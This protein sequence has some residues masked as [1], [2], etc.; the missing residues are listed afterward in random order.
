VFAGY[1]FDAV[2][3]KM[4]H[5]TLDYCLWE[6]AAYAL[7]QAAQPVYADKTQLLYPACPQFVKYR[8]PEMGALLVADPKPQAILDAV[9]VN[10]D[11][12]VYRFVD[13]SPVA[14]DRRH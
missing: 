8:Q 6:Y 2:T 11:Y 7:R 10:A 13:G 5:T 14:F 4:H 9:P 3:Y 1:I 12:A